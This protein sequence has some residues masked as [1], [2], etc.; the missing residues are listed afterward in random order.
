MHTHIH[1]HIAMNTINFDTFYS[2]FLFSGV[3]KMLED[4]YKQ[5]SEW[6]ARHTF[7]DSFRNTAE[8]SYMSLKSVDSSISS[9][10]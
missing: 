3:S 2:S 6:E 1:A 4:E 5:M 7:T 10:I 9:M 8:V